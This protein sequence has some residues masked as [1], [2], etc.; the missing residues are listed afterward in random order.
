MNYFE[1][2]GIPVSFTVDE[3]GIKKKYLELSRK[4]HPDFFINQSSQKQEEV[5]AAS[6][7]NTRAFE[8]LSDFDKRMKYV[9]E[10]KNMIH[11]RQRYELPPDFLMEMMGLNETLMEL[12]AKPDQKKI[13]DFGLLIS[14]FLKE[15]LEEVS[16]VVENYNDATAGEEQLKKIKVYYYKKKYLLRLKE[17]LDTFGQ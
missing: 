12:K 7:L 6:I 15:L 8:T 2:Y 16:S 14:D 3:D 1:F 10:L 13:A 17:S 4:Y 11:E 5:L 9:L